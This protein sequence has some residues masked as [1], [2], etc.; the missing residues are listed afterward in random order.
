M[1][2]WMCVECEC[3][4]ECESACTRM[5]ASARASACESTR[6]KENKREYESVWVC[7]SMYVWVWL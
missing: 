6:V 2:V 4:G 5:C 1:H 3:R 7:V